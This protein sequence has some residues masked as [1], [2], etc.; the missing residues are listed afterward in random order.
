MSEYIHS[1]IRLEILERHR[2]QLHVLEKVVRLDNQK[3]HIRWQI[4]NTVTGDIVS[5]K[6]LYNYWTDVFIEASA[7]SYETIPL[8]SHTNDSKK[9]SSTNEMSVNKYD[10]KVREVATH[11]AEYFDQHC[12]AFADVPEAFADWI[13][14][15]Y[16]AEQFPQHIIRDQ[17]KIDIYSVLEDKP[18][19]VWEVINYTIHKR[20]DV[21]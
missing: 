10:R 21:I 12:T 15:N 13:V 17:Q 4:R 3:P 18:A 6:S 9:N 8:D 16:I 7:K 2:G 1:Q 5:V 20:L 19:Q 11:L 14:D